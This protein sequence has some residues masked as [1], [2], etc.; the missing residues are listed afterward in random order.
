MGMRHRIRELLRI[1]ES[2]QGKV[3]LLSA[4]VARLE[5][6]VERPVGI[7]VTPETPEVRKA[8]QSS[9]E[10]DM[11]S[12]KL[13]KKGGALMG[14]VTG[15][16]KPK[17]TADLAIFDN[18]DDTATVQG[19]DAAGNAVDISAV[20][21][22]AVT[23]SDPSSLTVMTPTGMTFGFSALKPTVTGSPVIVT[24]VATFNDGS[25]GPFTVTLPVDISGTVATGLIV[26]PGTPTIRQ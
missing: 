5:R 23:S 17:A 11:A 1:C 14:G 18:Q 24:I 22:I 6:V 19:V 26:K 12:V 15:S 2:L 8:S 20:A 4:A 25:I 10:D 9:E 7:K 21:T 16:L 3:D 13:V